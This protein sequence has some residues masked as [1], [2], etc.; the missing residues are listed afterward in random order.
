MNHRKGLTLVEVLVVVTILSVLAL[1]VY[2]VF[3]SGV[4]AWSKAEERLDIYQ[5]ARVVLD[6]ISRELA[7]AFVDGANAKLVGTPGATPTDPDT[8]EFITDFSDSIY[9]IRYQLASDATYTSK[10]ALERGYID[11]SVDTGENYASTAY[12]T[13][14]FVP[15]TKNVEVSNIKFQYM[16]V[17][18]PPTPPTGIGDWTIST[19]HVWSAATLPE[20]VKVILTLK[21][22]N[23][24]IHDF[25]TIV[26]LPNSEIE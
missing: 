4:D 22:A 9:K 15:A 19:P 5:N 6:Q 11:Y 21:D 3:K 7:G 20:A 14:I 8:L 24:N 17:M 23:N 10:K 1:S 25:E 18:V 13:I 12:H 16:I 2:T 26:Y